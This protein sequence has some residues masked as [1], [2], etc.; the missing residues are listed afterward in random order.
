MPPTPG[1]KSSEFLLA[2][3]PNFLGLVLVVFGLY[4]GQEGLVTTG[5]VMLTGSSA[6]YSLSRGLSKMGTA[7][8][9][10][11]PPPANDEEAAKVLEGVK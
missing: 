11:N 5:M 1:M 6:G 3:I 10:A 4:K 2:L 9:V 7:Q 8:P